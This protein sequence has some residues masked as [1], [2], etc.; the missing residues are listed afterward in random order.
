MIGSEIKQSLYRDTSDYYLSTS[1]NLVFD[2]FIDLCKKHCGK[3]ILDIG[4][5]VGDYMVKLNSLGFITVGADVNPA[6]VEVAKSKGLY[7]H[8]IKDKLPFPDKSFDSVVLFEVL[9]H[10][11]DPVSVLTEAQRVAR[12]N[13]IITVPNCQGYD[14]L[15]SCGL[16]FEHFLD[17][18]HRNFFTPDSMKILI[19]KI[20][21]NYQ[22]SLGDPIISYN[23]IRKSIWRSFVHA[24]DKIGLIKPKY[25]FRIYVVIQL[26]NS[27]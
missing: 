9:E 4:C 7:V 26:S 8:L 6:Y 22:I 11:P 10:L 5:A 2:K 14:E 21:R 17:S 19:D 3:N 18:D 13:I 27:A 20:F 15:K 12:K 16:T 24:M 25:Y 1:N 23:L